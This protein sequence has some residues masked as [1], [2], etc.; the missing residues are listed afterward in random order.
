MSKIFKLLMSRVVIVGVLIAAQLSLIAIFQ[1]FFYEHFSKYYLVSVFIAL[2]LVFRIVSR[3]DNPGYKIAWIILIL[4]IPTFGAA[5]YLIFSG[6]QLTQH[7]RK[8]LAGMYSTMKFLLPEYTENSDRLFSDSSAKKQSDYITNTAYCPPFS[9]TYTQYIP[10]GEEYFDILC[11][12]LED[13]KSFIFLEYF[14]ID[15]G[16]MWDKIHD[17]LVQKA[18]EGVEVR[19]IYDDMGCINHL[20]TGFNRYLEKEGIKCRVFNRFIPVLS[21]RL[22]NRNHRKICVIDGIWGFTGGINIADEYINVKSPFGHWK[23]NAVLLQGK[24]VWSFTMMFLSMWENLDLKNKCDLSE[25]Q[26]YFPSEF[27]VK[28]NCYGIVQPYTDNPLDDNPVGENIYLNIIASAT[29]YVYITTPYLILDY[30]LEEALCSAAK[31]GV[32]VRIIVPGI[33]DKKLVYEATKSNYKKLLDSGVKIYEYTPGFIHAKTFLS[34]DEY[35]TVGTVNLDYRSLYLHFECGIWMY[36]T[37][38][39]EDIKA[40]FN[41]LFEVSRRV[42]YDDVKANILRRAARSVMDVMAPLI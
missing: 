15:K 16:Q 3:R 4:I 21:A 12:K 30:S 14:I 42:M 41:D 22:N 10:T 1:I 19:I 9:E 17:I 34:D 24:G 7:Q 32:D 13:A 36:K 38:V 28:A 39:L 31:S 37:P 27:D 26:R 5:V 11:E 35:G 40:D 20:D 29:K 33:P 18:K 25:Y 8:K 2:I 6:N 23:D